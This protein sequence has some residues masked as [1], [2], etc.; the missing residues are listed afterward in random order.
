MR[1]PVKSFATPVA[2][3]VNVASPAAVGVPEITPS[4]DSTSPAGSEPP[5]TSQVVFEG[6][7]DVCSVAE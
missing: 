3:T 5:V 4:F 6:I 2:L 7:P 1:V